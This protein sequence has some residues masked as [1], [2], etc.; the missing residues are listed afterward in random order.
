MS[1]SGSARPPAQRQ[2]AAHA[3]LRERCRGELALRP[4][5]V[6]E[7]RLKRHELSAGVAV[8]EPPFWGARVI[9]HVPVKALLP[10]LN[11]QMLYQFH[12]GYE[13][14]GRRLAEFL[15]WA[16]RSCGRC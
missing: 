16:T 1:P 6:E 8:P 10:Y 15:D 11:D 4:V 12:W 5:E 14:Q 13:K 7:I 9:E 3:G 2:E